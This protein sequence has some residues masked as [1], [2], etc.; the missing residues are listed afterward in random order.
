MAKFEINPSVV[1]NKFTFNLKDDGVE[2]IMG[3]Q[4]D[5]TDTVI[6]RFYQ[7]MLGCGH[8]ESAIA[9]AMREVSDEWFDTQ[10]SLMREVT[11]L[12]TD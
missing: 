9:S 6:E 12:V 7:F 11:D 3:F 1:Y 10:Q 8:A 5:S 4:A 2:Y